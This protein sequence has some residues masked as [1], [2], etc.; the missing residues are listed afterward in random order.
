MI[1]RVPDFPKNIRSILIHPSALHILEVFE[2][3]FF[4]PWLLLSPFLLF[5][6]KNA[7][8]WT[9]MVEIKW[10]PQATT[11]SANFSW[12][13]QWAALIPVNL[14]THATNH[15]VVFSPPSNDKKLPPSSRLDMFKINSGV[16]LLRFTAY[17]GAKS[18]SN[19]FAH[20]IWQNCVALGCMHFYDIEWM[21]LRKY[22]QIVGMLQSDS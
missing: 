8:H 4:S 6:T 16:S 12:L 10:W 2:K 11:Y 3:S 20:I 21:T 19:W 13:A 17:W 22:S 9:G 18:D 14:C 5:S 7:G 1:L 15:L